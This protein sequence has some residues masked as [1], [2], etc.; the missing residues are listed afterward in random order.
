MKKARK[1]C[2]HCNKELPDGFYV[3]I[4]ARH[5]LKDVHDVELAF[6]MPCFEEIAGSGYTKELAF[7]IK[8]WVEKHKPIKDWVEKKISSASLRQ[9]PILPG[10]Y[11]PLTSPWDY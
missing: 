1:I 3:S 9:K 4:S 7:K 6:H 5:I 8:E 11:N 10:R 2:H